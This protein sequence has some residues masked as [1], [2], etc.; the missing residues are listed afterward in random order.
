M[1]EIDWEQAARRVAF[2]VLLVLPPM[3]LVNVELGKTLVANV[4]CQ[5]SQG[6]AILD[7]QRRAFAMKQYESAVEE[8]RRRIEHEH[9]LFIFKFTAIGAVLAVLLH[10]VGGRGR[11]QSSDDFRQK[12]EESAFPIFLWSAVGISQVID[13]RMYFNVNMMKG[14][15]CWLRTLETAMY[16][17]VLDGWESFLSEKLTSILPSFMVDFDR[18]L[19]TYMLYIVALYATVFVG[20]RIDVRIAIFCVPASLALFAFSVIY[21]SYNQGVFLPG[22]V[23][24]G[25]VALAV[26]LGLRWTLL[27]S[28]RPS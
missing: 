6:P 8:I 7:E 19:L 28:E 25:V 1:S 11:G 26:L 17:G 5:V 24:G 2:F 22:V 23:G 14:L 3:F 16:G 18:F 4:E 27:R 10:S 15:G 12:L 13:E 20:R 9:L 21:R